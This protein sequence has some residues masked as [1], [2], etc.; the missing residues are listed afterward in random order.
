[1]PPAARI[2]GVTAAAVLLTGGGFAAGRLT[3][4]ERS[5]AASN[6]TEPR[7]LYREYI[8]SVSPDQ[9]VQEQRANGRMLANAI[10]QD[11][12]CFSASQ[13]AFAQTILDTIDQGLREDAVNNLRK[14]VEDATDEYSWSNC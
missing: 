10:L 3:A 1:M 12:D 14:C 11:P 8:D 13:R 2:L 6:C 9:A 5:T 7:E 4:P